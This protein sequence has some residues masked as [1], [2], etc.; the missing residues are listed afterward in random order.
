MFD[1]YFTNERV[2][3]SDVEAGY[4]KIR[5]G[6]YVETFISSFVRW[7]GADYEHQWVD[8]CERLI[9]GQEQSALI[10][11]Y[12]PPDSS[13]LLMWWPLYREGEVVHVR[14]ELLFYSQTTV[15]FSVD[16]P[17]ASIQERRKTN[18]EGL[19]I[20]EWDI[21]LACVHDFLARRRLK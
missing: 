1:I 4:G 18:D 9:S 10:T 16:S 5:I 12:V 17:W 7:N 3:E 19:E 14:N 11:S 2:P 21:S 13:D 8:A 15:P 20:S 6:N